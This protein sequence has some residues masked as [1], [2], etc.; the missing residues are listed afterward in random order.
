MTDTKTTAPASKPVP[1]AEANATKGVDTS[2]DTSKVTAAPI[3][4]SQPDPSLSDAEQ[5]RI[6]EVAQREQ[7]A[8][9]RAAEVSHGGLGSTFAANPPADQEEADARARALAQTDS[10]ENKI[11]RELSSEEPIQCIAKRD[12]FDERGALVKAGETYFYQEKNN[13]VFPYPNLE[14]VSKAKASALKKEYGD[15]VRDRDDTLKQRQKRRDAFARL[16]DE[17][18]V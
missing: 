7:L 16:A 8:L 4:D 5:I 18:G 3:E 13:E 10:I 11:A 2:V 15:Y 9:S 1:A 6:K 12:F 14:P 17:A